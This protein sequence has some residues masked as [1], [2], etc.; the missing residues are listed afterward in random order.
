MPLDFVLPHGQ[1]VNP[2]DDDNLRQIADQGNDSYDFVHLIPDMGVPE[3]VNGPSVGVSSISDG[4]YWEWPAVTA[5]HDLYFNLRPRPNWISGRFRVTMRLA[6]NDL[7]DD[8]DAWE[9]AL[10]GVYPD[11]S[12]ISVRTAS[13][14]TI[15]ASAS[16]TS[17]VIEPED[18]DD[19]TPLGDLAYVTARLR[20]DSTDMNTGVIWVYSVSMEYIDSLHTSHLV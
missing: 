7:A 1:I 11:G 6:F 20:R 3:A 2:G 16:P 12:T 17:A 4:P 19:S 9:M 14:P 10:G 13:F 18:W 15:T 8:S 5:D